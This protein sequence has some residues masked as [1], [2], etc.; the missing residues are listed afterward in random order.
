MR[1]QWL[2]H[3]S[4]FE[5][6]RKALLRPPAEAKNRRLVSNAI[7]R[8]SLLAGCCIFAAA[9]CAVYDDSLL[10]SGRTS[11]G[12]TTFDA[13]AGG[14]GGTG[15]GAGSA[16]SGGA[17]R[18]GESGDADWDGSESGTSG[19]A[20]GNDAQGGAGGAA[21]SAGSS[22]ST[23]A[24]GGG[25]GAGGSGASGAGGIAGSAGA[26]GTGGAA[27]SAGTAGTAG[28]GGVGGIDGG[29]GGGGGMDGGGGKGG[30]SGAGGSP[31]GG[32]SDGGGPCPPATVY[33]DDFEN[34]TINSMPIGWTRV[35]GSNGDWQ[36]LAD[37]SN[38]FAQNNAL[39]S[40]FRLC[41]PNGAPGAPWSGATTVSAHVKILASG[42]SGTPMALLCLGYGSGDYACIALQAGSGARIRLNAG[43][44]PIDGPLWPAAIAAG[45]WD[46]VRLSIDASGTLS[47]YLNGTLL[48]SYMPA[49]TIAPGYVAVATQGAQAEFDTVAVTQP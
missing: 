5:K 25:A 32:G 3:F 24:G 42:S 41:Y 26:A 30:T 36:V 19:G 18:D 49:V 45:S 10:T 11:V 17:G 2:H 47:A 13:N 43:S 48:G 12:G 23:G 16:G 35:G 33:C 37:T 28:S 46:D 6:A 1:D 8:P 34:D 15:G 20:G 14:S 27:G 39:S 38:V 29:T 31:D 7:A 21:G 9:S 40:T 22:G 44:S 4:H